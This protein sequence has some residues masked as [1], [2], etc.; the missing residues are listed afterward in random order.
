MQHFHFLRLFF[1]NMMI[2]I[3]FYHR[4]TPH[5]KRY[6]TIFLD[7]TPGWNIRLDKK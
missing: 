7:N 2:F 6:Q 1:Y 4:R 3:T 5:S